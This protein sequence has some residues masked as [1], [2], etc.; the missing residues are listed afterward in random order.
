MKNFVSCEVWGLQ[1]LG[2]RQVFSSHENEPTPK[3]CTDF[4]QNP[5]LARQ[6]RSRG[7]SE[8]REQRLLLYITKATLKA[9]LKRGE[10]WLGKLAQNKRYRGYVFARLLSICFIV[11]GKTFVCWYKSQRTQEQTF[12]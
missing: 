10:K 5:A 8:R 11:V 9:L 12:P 2:R 7:K 1:E 4:L 6:T 3:E